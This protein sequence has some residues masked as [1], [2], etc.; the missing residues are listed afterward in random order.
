MYAGSWRRLD[1]WSAS[2]SISMQLNAPWPTLQR[3]NHQ[4]DVRGASE[5]KKLTRKVPICRRES[6]VFPIL[7]L[8]FYHPPAIVP[9]HVPPFYVCFSLFKGESLSSLP[10]QRE[11]AVSPRAFFCC[12]VAGHLT[13]PS[14]PSCFAVLCLITSSLQPTFP[15]C[16]A[17]SQDCRSA[18]VAFKNSG[19][20]PPTFLCP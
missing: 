10:Y 5:F 17:P 1:P 8:Y 11:G 12:T 6:W 9:T 2:I 7:S 16:H 18:L 3:R 4:M 14:S 20:C 19:S 13:Y 15:R